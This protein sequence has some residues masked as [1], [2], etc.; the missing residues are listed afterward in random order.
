MDKDELQKKLLDAYQQVWKIY[1][2]KEYDN[3]AKISY[4][5]WKDEFASKYQ[6]EKYVKQFWETLL[7]SYKSNTFEMQPLKD[8]KIDFFAEGKLVALMSTNPDFRNRGNTVLWAKVKLEGSLRPLY[9]NRYFYI[10]E[11]ET[12]FKVY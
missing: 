4:D 5:T 12:E 2:N 9:I 6:D 1:N 7:E 8:Y 3:I 10:P 11:G